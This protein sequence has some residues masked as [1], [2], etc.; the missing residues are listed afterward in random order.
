MASLEVYGG[1]GGCHRLK[2][3]SATGGKGGT[4]N[5][6]VRGGGFSIRVGAEKIVMGGEKYPR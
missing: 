2:R 3:L 4:T 5:P 6:F 1:L